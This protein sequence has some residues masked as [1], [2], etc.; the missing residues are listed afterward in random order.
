MSLPLKSPYH[1]VMSPNPNP[2]ALPKTCVSKIIANRIKGDL[3][4]LV[5]INQSAFVPGRRISDNILLTQ[6]LMRNYHRNCGPPRCSFKIDIQKAYDTVDWGFLRS[7]LIGFGFHP[8]MVEWIMV[9]VST[10]SYSVCINGNLHG[11]FNGKRGLRQGD[12]LSPYL[13]TLVMEVLTLILQRRVSVAENFRYHHH[14][15]KQCIVNLC[16]ADDLFLFARGHLNSVTIIMEA[17]EEFK[18]VSSLV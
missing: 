16:F 8:T 11:W 3:G 14:C 4:D 2:I 10:T 1:I 12:P 9:C 13:F 7:I 18:N 17:L 15:E 5:S 6:E